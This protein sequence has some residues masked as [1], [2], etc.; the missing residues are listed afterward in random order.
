MQVTGSRDESGQL[1]FAVQLKRCLLS[2][3][4]INNQSKQGNSQSMSTVLQYLLP[5]RK[6]VLRL[7]E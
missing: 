2:K 4:P 7:S 6:G 3:D 1:K 5:E